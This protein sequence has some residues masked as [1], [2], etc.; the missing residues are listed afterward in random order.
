MSVFIKVYDE[1]DLLHNASE[2]RELEHHWMYAFVQHLSG[3][4]ELCELFYMKDEDGEYVLWGQSSDDLCDE[5]EFNHIKEIDFGRYDMTWDEY[6]L[7]VFERMFYSVKSDEDSE[8]LENS[9]KELAKVREF[10]SDKIVPPE[11]CW[12]V[13]TKEELVEYLMMRR[14][15][16]D[17]LKP[18]IEKIKEYFGVRKI[19]ISLHSD[20]ECGHIELNI[21]YANDEED[22]KEWDEKEWEKER[23]IEDKFYE[24]YWWEKDEELRNKYPGTDI[25]LDRI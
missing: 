16:V 23:E 7:S 10:L 24:E 5:D 1:R 22:R 19:E 11:S 4:V 25:Y 17:D 12:I 3:D 18:V 8:I 6:R 20:P 15:L 21:R 9:K 13:M 14:G 2:F